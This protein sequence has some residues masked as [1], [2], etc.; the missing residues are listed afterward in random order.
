M[1]K[2]IK[3]AAGRT[4]KTAPWLLAMFTAVALAVTSAVPSLQ[5]ENA[6]ADDVGGLCQSQELELGENISVNEPDTGVATWVG[7]D[8]YVGGRPPRYGYQ[9]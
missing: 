6:V 8:M 1:R 5:A 2:R 7:R 4:T 9:H 3:T